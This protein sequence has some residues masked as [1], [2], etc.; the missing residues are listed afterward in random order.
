VSPIVQYEEW[1]NLSG[2][3]HRAAKAINTDARIAA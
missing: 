2:A 1:T 3:D